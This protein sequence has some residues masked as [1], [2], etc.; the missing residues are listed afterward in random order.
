M[1]RQASLHMTWHIWML[2]SHSPVADSCG[3]ANLDLWRNLS[4]ALAGQVRGRLDSMKAEGSQGLIIQ[5]VS[6]SLHMACLGFRLMHRGHQFHIL[7][8]YTTFGLVEF[9]NGFY[10]KIKPLL[11][12]F[13]TPGSPSSLIRDSLILYVMGHWNVTRHCNAVDANANTAHLF[14]LKCIF[15]LRSWVRKLF[16][17]PHPKHRLIMQWQYY[18]TAYT[19]K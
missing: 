14:F 12:Q 11:I 9:G 4:Q 1:T 5:V 2:V 15:F 16:S 10:V 13:Q 3:R 19:W 7:W 17:R 8:K 6:Y 18:L